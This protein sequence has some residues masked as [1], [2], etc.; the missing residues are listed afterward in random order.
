[1]S[2]VDP[3]ELL[4]DFGG[5]GPVVHLAHANGFPPGAYRPFIETL[6]HPPLEGSV[7]PRSHHVVALPA[8]PLW[9]DSQPESAPDWHVLAD[10]LIQSLDALALSGITGVGHSMGG[11]YTMLAAIR[12]PDIFQV[13]ILIDPVILPPN[14]LRVLSVMRRLGLRNRQPLVQ[15]ALRRRRTWPSREDC[16]ASYRSK[17][18]FAGWS[19][20]SLWAYVEAGTRLRADDQV[21]LVYPV[22][23]EAQI[24]ATSPTDVWG[25]VPQLKTPALVIRGEHSN[26]FREESH[27][28]MERL[29]PQARYRVIPHSGHLVP[30]ERP[31]E[32]GTVVREFLAKA[33]DRES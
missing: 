5:D 22:Q 12:R 32:T 21:E 11:V 29:L 31:V 1:V 24:F 15:G 6:T 7:L 17:A 20:E 16:Y 23:W 8:R 10:D 25:F 14:V 13:V 27:E 33:S 18:F 3:T 30:M 19:D 9:P 26:T 4:Q 28:R 2:L